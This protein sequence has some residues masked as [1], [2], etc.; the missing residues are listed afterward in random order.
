M[1]EN[2]SNKIYNIIL[3][4]QIEEDNRIYKWPKVKFIENIE[5][6][7]QSKLNLKV[8]VDQKIL[9][10]KLYNFAKIS[11]LSVNDFDSY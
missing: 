3:Q 9:Y 7:I 2:E 1:P 8:E 11:E 10:F 5:N 6:E 4:K